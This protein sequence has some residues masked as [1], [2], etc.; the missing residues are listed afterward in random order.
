MSRIG[1]LPIDIPTG[2]SVELNGYHVT[3][4]GPNG[5]LYTILFP[6]DQHFKGR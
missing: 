1:K 5:S 4:K 2:I 6:F 3:V